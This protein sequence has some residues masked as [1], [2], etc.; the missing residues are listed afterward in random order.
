M[1]LWRVRQHG[2]DVG[3]D[4]LDD[5]RPR[6]APAYQL[7]CVCTE[8][9]GAGPIGQQLEAGPREVVDTVDEHCAFTVLE[10]DALRPE[11]RR[12]DGTCIRGRFE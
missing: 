9:L 11:A 3:T 6:V 8:P 12:Y 1:P 7:P 5:R 10:V 2:V 4:A